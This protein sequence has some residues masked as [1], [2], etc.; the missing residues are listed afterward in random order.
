MIL[1]GLWF[2]DYS[3]INRSIRIK[4]VRILSSESIKSIM[5]V[6]YTYFYQSEN[7]HDHMFFFMFV[8]NI[9]RNNLVYKLCCSTSTNMFYVQ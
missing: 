1:C 5:L 2:N 3:E 8:R 6:F 9:M 4:W 7:Q